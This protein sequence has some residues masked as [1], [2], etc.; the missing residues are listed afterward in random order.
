MSK[1]T[2][3]LLILTLATACKSSKK[4]EQYRTEKV[5]RGVVTETVSATGTLSAVTTVQVGSQVSGVISRLYADFNSEV[6]KGQLL[7]ELD[8]TPFQAQVEQRQADVTRARVETANAKITY[9]RQRRLAAAG[10][11]A[12]ADLDAAKAQY[13]ASEAQVDQATAALQQSLTNL[14]YTKILSPID[15]KVIDRQYDVGQTVAASFQAPTLFAIAQDLTKMQVQADV[16]QSDIG[17]VHVGQLA[18][19]TVDAYPEEEFRGRISQM[20]LNATVSQNVVSYPVMIEVANPQERLSP[21]MTANVTIDVASVRDVLRIPNA[22]LRFKP[23][24]ASGQNANTPAKTASSGGGESQQQTSTEGSVQRMGRRRRGL[25]GAAGAFGGSVEKPKR[26]QTVYVLDAQKKPQPVQIRTGITD[27]RFTQVVDGSL[28][29]G[30]EVITG[31]ATS[32]VEGPAAFGGGMGSGQ[33]G[34][35]GGRGPR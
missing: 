10:L 17:R 30:D 2:T 24:S 15:G 18:R 5:G 26:P 8:P 21:K 3:I 12:Q 20:R 23:E 27:G 19:F 6:K 7:A 14:R 34:G 22:A 33:R 13:Q 9:E 31:L 1:T 29:P 25:E 4:D 16:D 32:K 11:A 35:G 28:K